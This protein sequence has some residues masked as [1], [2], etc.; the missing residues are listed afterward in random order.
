MTVFIFTSTDELL[1]GVPEKMKPI[2]N[3]LY[4]LKYSTGKNVLYTSF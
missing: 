2:F 4:L 3:S 1:Q